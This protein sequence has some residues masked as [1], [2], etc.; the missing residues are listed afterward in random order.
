MEVTKDFY[1]IQH[2]DK[3]RLF[4]RMALQIMYDS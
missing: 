1:A 3:M 2:C 4:E